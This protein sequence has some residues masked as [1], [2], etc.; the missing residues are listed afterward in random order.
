MKDYLKNQK[1]IT[2]LVLVVTIIILLIIAVITLRHGL[3]SVQSTQNSVIETNLKVVQQAVLQEFAKN[4]VANSGKNSEEQVYIGKRQSSEDLQKLLEDEPINLQNLGKDPSPYYI[5]NSTDLEQ[6]GI[7]I[8]MGQE[9][10]VDYETGEIWD[11]TNKVYDDGTYAYLSGTTDENTDKEE[12]YG[13]SNILVTAK[14]NWVSTYD[15]NYEI[16]LKITDD[17]YKISE[18]DP[19]AGLNKS[20]EEQGRLVIKINEHTIPIKSISFSS[21]DEE[22]EYESEIKLDK[23]EVD[24]IIGSNASSTVKIQINANAIEDENG[25]KNERQVITT[26]ITSD[27][28]LDI[29]YSLGNLRYETKN[30]DAYYG[31]TDQNGITWGTG[32]RV[33]LVLTNPKGFDE[34]TYDFKYVWKEGNDISD[35][36][37]TEHLYV[38]TK[39]G[40]TR[41]VATIYINSGSGIGNLYIKPS[42]STDFNQENAVIAVNLD[43]TPPKYVSY[44]DESYAENNGIIGAHA[45]DDIWENIFF[46][47]NKIAKIEDNESGIKAELDQRLWYSQ[48]FSTSDTVPP[49]T[50]GW[51]SSFHV[52]SYVF[53]NQVIENQN[54]YW[55]MKLITWS[56]SN[57]PARIHS[58]LYYLWVIYSHP[59]HNGEEIDL[60]DNVGNVIEEPCCIGPVNIDMNEPVL[61]NA[62]ITVDSEG[63]SNAAIK[64][65][66]DFSGLY[67]T[68]DMLKRI[69]YKW[70][71]K[72]E[73]LDHENGM[74]ELTN[75]NA[76]FSIPSQ[77]YTDE[78]PSY[79]TLQISIPDP[80]PTDDKNCL[81]LYIDKYMDF[82]GNPLSVDELI[83]PTI[84]GLDD[85]QITI[86]EVD[87]S[88]QITSQIS[89]PT[90]VQVKLNPKDADGNIDQNR[91]YYVKELSYSH[92]GIDDKIEIPLNGVKTQKGVRFKGECISTFESN[93]NG[94]IE[95]SVV[96]MNSD[97][98]ERTFTQTYQ[99]KNIQETILKINLTDSTKMM[100]NF[101]KEIY[102]IFWDYRNSGEI[103]YAQTLENFDFSDMPLMYIQWDAD[104]PNNPSGAYA[105]K[106]SIYASDIKTSSAELIML[107]NNNL[108]KTASHD[109]N[110][111][112]EYTIKISGPVTLD[113]L[114]SSL[115]YR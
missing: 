67:T 101:S 40:N 2:L 13:D 99:I 32:A 39:K 89:Y 76:T 48:G 66:D 72:D 31:Y 15:G 85:L 63:N 111:L 78:N 77:F 25:E 18:S 52:F 68:Q 86:N 65:T 107:N 92:V 73:T 70:V 98:T 79:N 33:D 45:P 60:T 108:Y 23:N 104:N 59:I 53:G 105:N 47:A 81:Y 96:V 6:I 42:S 54:K 38:H 10:L 55:N 43:N 87:Q 37:Y 97:G 26:A 109:Y 91:L 82:S 44:L 84:E 71:S 74:T 115:L 27:V 20:D 29:S 49:S 64:I 56:G 93:V 7:E 69:T 88:G 58:G 12:Y 17:L 5:V 106:Y 80:D 21:T 95:V 34:K 14:T 41:Q 114:P 112:G 90:T 19:E 103:D 57:I 75:S 4:N 110:S 3:V 62:S 113:N 1:G 30:E 22:R 102:Y 61:E 83:T 8:A 35:S 36:D 50:M 11:V 28:Q 46:S 94:P 100:L 51:L 24:S 9:Y 16:K